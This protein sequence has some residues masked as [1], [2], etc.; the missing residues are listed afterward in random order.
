MSGAAKGRGQAS[1]FEAQRRR[2]RLRGYDQWSNG[3][4]VQTGSAK[5]PVIGAFGVR[6]GQDACLV[7]LGL[8]AVQQGG[9][10]EIGVLLV[11]PFPLSAEAEVLTLL[12]CLGMLLGL[13][14]TCTYRDR[15]GGG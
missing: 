11:L 12:E 9:Q 2:G 6:T 1:L 14:G 10:I 13:R 4:V 5:S 3:L 7:V 15:E 8:S